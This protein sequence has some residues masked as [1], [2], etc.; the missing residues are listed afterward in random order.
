M[1]LAE[2][3]RKITGFAA[4]LALGLLAAGSGRAAERPAVIELF[5]SQGCSSCPPADR[6]MGELSPQPNLIVLSFPVDIWDY[7]GWK[8]TLA[9]PEFTARQRVYAATRGDHQVYTPQA[10]VDGVMHV[11]GSDKQQVLGTVAKTR[12]ERAGV[13]TSIALHEDHGMVVV[14]LGEAHGDVGSGGGV[15]LLRVA[16][17]RAVAIGRGENSG[18]KVTYTNVV[19]SI[20]RMGYWT[21]VPARFELPL[22]EAQGEGAD[23]YVVLVQK[24]WGGKL[25]PVLAAAKSSNL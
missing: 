25:G 18:H 5:T 11:V 23:G 19:R 14:D 17:S 1:V 15:W 6:L 13:G 9:K 12:D 2:R 21:G 10:V 16:R 24:N 20:A 22:A 4:V 3:V 7:I 8:D